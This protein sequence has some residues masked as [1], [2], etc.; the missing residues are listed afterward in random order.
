MT[1]QKIALVTDSTSDIP[2]E[3]REK[4]AIEI[5]PLTVIFGSQQFLDGIELTATQFY[6]RLS[7]D[8]IHPTTSQPS[9]QAYRDAFDRAVSRGAEQI[10]TITISSGLSG[11]VESARQAAENYSVPVHV[12]DSR[13]TSMG[14][15]WQVLAAARVQEAG[16]GIKEMMAAVEYAR[17]S[18][19]FYV[20]LDTIEFLARGG[21]I[22][23]AARF[24]D[25]VLHIKPMIYVK[26]ETGTVGAALPSRSRKSAVQ[27]LYKEFFNHL[28]PGKNLRIAVTHTQALA[29]AEVLADQIRSEYAPHELII[30]IG[31]PVLGVHVGMK[32]LALI[33]Y[34]E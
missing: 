33:G 6:E 20:S 8:A 22:S 7:Q 34:A 32:A 14:L 3:W 30:V 1:P 21:R 24:L 16:G 29:E 10:L 17:Q 5:V 23:E 2:A 9:P 25:S 26:T 4:Y 15:G 18:M 31:A 11:T 12:M 27:S 13:S 28:S 19:V